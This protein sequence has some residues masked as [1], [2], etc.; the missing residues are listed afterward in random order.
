MTLHVIR[1]I[2]TLRICLPTHNLDTYFWK[3]IT[4]PYW[5][6][7][8]KFLFLQLPSQVYLLC[9]AGNDQKNH[10][11]VSEACMFTFICPR[12]PYCR[13]VGS[14]LSAD[15]FLFNHL[16]EYYKNDSLIPTN[17]P[18]TIL[19]GVNRK[20]SRVSVP[21]GSASFPW[22]WDV[23][24]NRGNSIPH[25]GLFLESQENTSQ[26]LRVCGTP[27]TAFSKF[28]TQVLDSYRN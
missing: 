19:S 11:N 2:L 4:C 18:S 3:C 6:S 1:V 23:C 5:F 14:H 22:Q 20:A 13:I 24:I 8:L 7:D 26:H 17:T 10:E 16:R 15:R 9:D 28:R 12:R 21:G 27:D 25:A